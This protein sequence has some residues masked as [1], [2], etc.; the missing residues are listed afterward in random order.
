MK[1]KQL[2]VFLENRPGQL[3]APVQAL[4][5]EGVNIL[6][7]SLA[8]TTEFGILRL[9]V[10]DWER[11]KDVLEQAGWVVNLSDVVAIGVADRPGGLSEVLTLLAGEGVNIEYLY[12]FALRRDDKAIL[13]IRFEDPE[14]ALQVV[15]DKGL[16]VVDGDQ[17][18]ALVS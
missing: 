17:L 18:V 7:L 1:L 4:A 5:Q 6:T 12:A 14:S 2:S 10:D 8:D 13:I 9:I 16:H 11:A 15:L 3:A